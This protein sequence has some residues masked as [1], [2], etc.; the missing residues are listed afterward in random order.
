MLSSA[1]LNGG[2]SMT[3]ALFIMQV[4][5]DYFTE[6][7]VA[8]ARSVCGAIGLPE[9]SVGMMTA[10]EVDHVFN[11][12]VEEFNGCRVVAVATA[13]L[14]NHIVAGDVLDDWDE[15]HEISLKRGAR[16]AG[17]INIAVITEC[18]LTQSAKVNLM[19]P[20]VEAKTAALND[21]GYR[22]TGTTSDSMAVISPVGEDRVDYAGTG[23]DIGIAAARAVRKAVGFALRIRD[24][25]PIPT[26]VVKALS[27]RGYDVQRLHSICG[28]DCS[29]E[30]FERSLRELSEDMRIRVLV[31]HVV[32]LSNRSDSIADDGNR[33]TYNIIACITGYF[34]GYHGG[35]GVDC[36][37]TL[38]HGIAYLAGANTDE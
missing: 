22:E 2:D 27:S 15:K 5:K 12:V 10:A 16:L 7:P 28:H 3:T 24:E 34:T 35:L 26:D 31:D 18:P 36:I 1:I 37:D 9:D 11:V 20:L 25:H 29:F 19:I 38:A 13:G 21:A 23:T 6:D 32:Y 14:S 33:E 17:T 8:H 30:S 4:C